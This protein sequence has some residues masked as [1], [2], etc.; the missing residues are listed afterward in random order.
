MNPSFE[1]FLRLSPADRAD[2]FA[3][4]AQRLGTVPPYVEKDFWVSLILDSLYNDIP[5]GHPKLLF[6]GGT[7]LSKAFDL[8][9]RFSE[10][11]D[12]VVFRDD[13]GFIAE[14]DPTNPAIELSG[15]KRE[16]L[17]GDLRAASQTYIQGDLRKALD[18][19][20]KAIG[21]N[22]TISVDE[23]DLD[24]QT[25][26]INYPS[27]FAT[28]D[29]A[30]ILPRVKIEGGARSALNPHSIK[31]IRPFIAGDLIDW[32]FDIGGIRTINPERT[33][34]EKLLILHG[35]H[36]GFRDERRLPS[37][38][39][40]ISRHYHD[41]AV[42]SVTEI[43]A[44]ALTDYALLTEVREHNCLA[45]RQAWK[46]FDEAVPGTL[47]VVPQRE[48]RRVIERDYLA[49]QGMLLGDG[50][51]FDWIIERLEAIEAMVNRV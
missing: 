38:P 16:A 32:S 10:D 9:R 30:Y 26:L 22:C 35:A 7:S 20:L 45:F 50:P 14:R 6:K 11:V 36:C 44:R 24:G 33:Y 5:C 8:I 37:E 40:R 25:L 15:K 46:K 21:A 4:A 28:N 34:L 19:A 18:G 17:F 42:I 48:L 51:H 2:V 12:I 47:R 29:P 43:G 41:V 49:M 3:A 23:T 27:L 31:T 39:D 1:R 13:L